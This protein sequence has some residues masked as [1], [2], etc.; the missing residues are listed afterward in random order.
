MT[1]CLAADVGTTTL[2]ASLVD[3]QSGRIAAALS[4]PNSQRRFGADVLTRL[5]GA[6]ITGGA[7]YTAA[8]WNDLAGLFTAL[9]RA[10]DL[11]G[12]EAEAPR[13]ELPAR[14]GS[15][16][17]VFETEAFR[18]LSRF[19]AGAGIGRVALC[20][21]TVMTH[22]LLGYPTDGLCEAPF[23]PYSAAPVCRSAEGVDWTVFPCIGAFLGGDTVSGLY[24]LSAPG[25]R[26][27]QP[28]GPGKARMLIDLGT[29]GELVLSAPDGMTAASVAAGP[30]FEGG[31]L[32]CG[33]PSVAGAIRRVRIA[34]D[35]CAVETIGHAPAAGVC[36]SGAVEALAQLRK[37]GIV[38]AHGTLADAYLKDGFVL[39]ENA[40]SR[41]VLTQDDIRQ[42]QL[43]K[44]AVAAGA[45]VLLNEA[46]LSE[47]ALAEVETAGCFGSAVPAEA[48]RQI[49]LLPE[50]AQTAVQS[51]GNLALSGAE[52]WLRDPD[53]GKLVSLAKSVHVI[54]LAEHPLFQEKFVEG[55]EL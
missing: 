35:R 21:N 1:V 47:D 38:D 54:S 37:N 48:V 22:F 39:A 15:Q 34:K 13:F 8:V 5:M 52:A 33:M 25:G 28:S 46:G 40:K 7:R 16:P 4:R 9:L 3:V 29:N 19:L 53:P 12:P 44:G 24:A 14:P 31:H 2:A 36:G 27:E 50:S 6:R 49:R 43:A 42:I 18:V 30:A 10:A 32:S 20:G 17:D 55:M 45:A 41:I 23:V 51:A 11:C 26:W